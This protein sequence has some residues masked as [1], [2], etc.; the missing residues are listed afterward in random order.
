MSF[1]NIFRTSLSTVEIIEAS[2]TP[3]ISPAVPP[4]SDM[5]SNRVY[6]GDSVS[7][8]IVSAFNEPHLT[9]SIKYAYLIEQHG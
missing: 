6:S 2:D 7:V 1:L 5:N 3:R 8:K 4:M 9:A